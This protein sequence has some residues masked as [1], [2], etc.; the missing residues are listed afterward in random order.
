MKESTYPFSDAAPTTFVQTEKKVWLRRLFG[1]T[2]GFGGSD[3]SLAQ[4]QGLALVDCS[5]GRA[6]GDALV[7]ETIEFTADAAHFVWRA[8]QTGLAI[9]SRWTFC[10]RT[11]IWSRQDTL[12]NRGTEPVTVFKFLARFVFT[13]GAYELYCQECRWSNENRGGWTTLE[14]GTLELACEQARTCLG[15]TPYLYVR[16]KDRQT[17]V[18]F[19]LLPVGN[20]LIRIRRQPIGPDA[21]PFLVVEAGQRIE[22]LKMVVGPGESV[23]APEILIQ[24]GPEGQ[25]HLAAPR[26][27]RYVLPRYFAQAKTAAPLVYNTWFDWFDVLSLDRMRSQL[28]AAKDLGC[29]VFTIDAGWFGAGEGDWARQTGDWREKRDGAFHGNMKAFADEV[30]AAGLGFGLWMEPERAC[31]DVPPVKDH[32]EYFVRGPGAYYPKLYDPKAREYIFGE[33]CRLVE[34]YQLAWMKIDFNNAFG[35]D[36]SGTEFHRYYLAWYD[37]MEMLKRKYPATFFEGCASGGMR[38]DLNALRHCDGHFLSDTVNP[39]DALRI[40]QGAALRLPPGRFT[41]WTALRAIGNQV[42]LYPPTG[43]NAPTSVITPCG[44]TWEPSVMVDPEFAVAPCL[45]GMLGFTGDLA[46][47]PPEVRAVLKRAVAFY[48]KWREYTSGAVCHL[49]TPPARKEDRTGWLGL[50]L[51]HPE[52]PANLVFAYRLDEFCGTHHFCLRELPP[53]QRYEIRTLGRSE[54]RTCTGRELTGNG[55]VVELPNRFRA[56]VMEIVPV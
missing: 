26:L 18:A 53:D 32:P 31:F 17:G 37:L 19:H 27:H 40:F 42:A 48:K 20:W 5:T 12:T 49:L 50:Q 9:D 23:A 51:Q 45:T 54:T 1:L 41:L 56:A 46:G 38:L 30:R 7:P 11:G 44:A 22:D 25:P 6:E 29:E 34:T 39:I 8:G 36:P 52:N 13:P 28:A 24:A 33:I 16:D 10:G 2:G 35:V 3:D 21:T 15:S 43:L 14:H 47:L 4:A 55:L